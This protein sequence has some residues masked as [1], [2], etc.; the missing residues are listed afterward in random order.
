MTPRRN[1]RAKMKLPFARKL[2]LQQWALGEC[3]VSGFA[4]LAG[5]LSDARE[6]LD[7]SNV[8]GFHHELCR[9]P[10]E[11]RPSLPDDALL[12]HDQS[13]VSVTQKLNQSR[14]RHGHRPIQWKYFQYLSL[15]FTEIYLERYFTDPKALRASLNGVIR[16]YND[17]LPAAHAS[18]RLDPL[19][20]G[21]DPRSQLNKLAFWMATGSG[22]TLL[23]HAHIL[24]YAELAR[25]HGPTHHLN[26]I[27]LLTPNE[28]LSHQHL[29]EFEIAGIPAGI[30]SKDGGDLFQRGSVEILDVHKLAAD[31][32]DKTVAVS[33]LEGPNL[34]LIDEGHR[35]ASSG[36]QGTWMAYRNQLCEGG[37]SFEYSATF[38]QAIK[39]DRELTDEYARSTL[40]DYSYRW[41]HGDGFGKDYRIVNMNEDAGEWRTR[42]LTA[43]LLTFFQQ[44]WI[45][46]RHGSD[47][48]PFNVEPPLWVFVGSKV[49]KSLSVKDASDVVEILRF[50]DG[51]LSERDASVDR[52]R[53]TLHDD[54]RVRHDQLRLPGDFNPLLDAGL[55]AEQVY[56]ETLATTFNAPS[57]GTLRVERLKGSAGELALR[58]GE[59]NEP[60]G[61]VNVGDP[62][63]LAKRCE[64]AGLIVREREFADSVFRSVNE[65]DSRINVVVGAKKF[66]EGWNSWRV[67]SMGLMN[68]GKSEGSQIIQLFGRGVRLKGRD[69]SLKRSSADRSA[70]AE[71]RPTH[72]DRLETLHVFG[73][74]AGYM[75]QFRD[76]LKEEGLAADPV[77]EFIPIRVPNLPPGLK[78]IRV[79]ESV[80]RGD[81]AGAFRRSG[82]RFAL[83]TPWD[84][85]LP[86]AVRRRLVTPRVPLDWRPRVQTIRSE[87]LEG[88][89][90]DHAEQHEEKLLGRHLALFDT[91]ALCLSLQRFKRER[92]W[93]GL[94]IAKSVVNELLR[95]GDWYR[96]IIPPDE[97]R[98][99]SMRKARMWQDIAL[100]LLK[101][102]V[103]R[104]WGARRQAWEAEHLEYRDLKPE[105]GNFPRVMRDGDE[106]N[107][108]RIVIAA[109]QA[110]AE[111]LRDWIEEVRQ[112]IESG[113]GSLPPNPVTNQPAL[114]AIAMDQHLYSPLLVTVHEQAVTVSPPGLNA[115][116]HR[117]VKDFRRHCEQGRP[118]GYRLHLL[119]NMS[120]GHGI[121][122][123][124]ANNFHPDF[125]LWAVSGDRQH[126]AFIDPKGLVRMGPGDPKILLSKQIEE[127]RNRLGDPNVRLD[128]FILSV[129]PFE[130]MGPA[131]KMSKD[132]MAELH[133]LFMEDRDTYVAE[134][135]RRMGV[136]PRT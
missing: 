18:D 11:L 64:E 23:M 50:L 79:A 87:A 42:Y 54:E 24:R 104:Y 52:I 107:G 3:G 119:R 66:T 37:F 20:T 27:L 126:I 113:V 9:I 117:F 94:A 15:L 69:M 6:G 63:K 16:S 58:V 59:T 57:G 56:R 124:E 90:D 12:A 21:P 38:G 19:P 103:T 7:E 136:A 75:A 88:W 45:Y 13:V 43:A 112:V 131:W 110:D 108:Y 62:A 116:E 39:G 77:E 105:D 61:V 60:F 98:F 128:S 44:Q 121:G 14:L 8:H 35:G 49:T 91:D 41:F 72:L 84:E 29:E 81:P 80:A 93:H 118:E 2:V 25:K 123:F 48:R 76:F 74:R 127:I 122:F 67:S 78:M 100:A 22:K 46:R 111:E 10:H 86:E 70:G 1:R 17:A 125:I 28:G 34:V 109:D 129:T 5:R 73:V 130:T 82:P 33:A 4:D 31:M 85:E 135:L 40:V 83:R 30:F 134:M 132:E 97:L 95:V 101:K 96:L 36:K 114:D 92:G 102:Y 68:V 53:G 106:T 120:R 115:G 71:R 89:G 99:D 26:R 133:V 55:D 47:Y 51:Y 32:G 65:P